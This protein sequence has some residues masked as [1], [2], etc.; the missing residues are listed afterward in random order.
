MQRRYC[1]P[2]L[3]TL[4]AVLVA[5]CSSDKKPDTAKVTGIVKYKGK[6]V[7]GAQVTFIVDG[8]MAV[9][10]TGD[11]GRFTIEHVPIGKAQV[12]IVKFTGSE[13]A[14]KGEYDPANPENMGTGSAPP[15][16]PNTAAKNELPKKYADKDLS[17]LDQ[18]VSTDESSNDFTFELS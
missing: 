18:T 2:I 4:A 6:P 11:D 13:S 16:M 15:N 3:L 1:S 14:G 8:N 10:N 17:G 7:P 5:G 12:T 9:A